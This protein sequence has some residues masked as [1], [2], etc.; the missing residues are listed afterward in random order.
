MFLGTG[1][2][3]GAVVQ[4][5]DTFYVY[6]NETFHNA[7]AYGSSVSPGSILPGATT[8]VASNLNLAGGNAN[9]GYAFLASAVQDYLT[10][11]GSALS[12]GFRNGPSGLEYFQTWATGSIT[13]TLTIPSAPVGAPFG[14]VGHLMLG[15][16]VTGSVSPGS[17]G[18][19]YM[20]IFAHTSPSLPNTSSNTV[21]IYANGHYNLGSPMSFY[22]D[23]PFT[24]TI[25]SNVFAAVAYDYS[26]I[27]SPAPSPL[28][29]TFTNTSSANFLHTALL[30]SAS[31]LDAFGNP[32]EGTTIN[33]SSG[34]PFPLPVPEPGTLSLLA[35]GGLALIRR[36][37][38]G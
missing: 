34:L 13:E 18:S 6:A 20:G 35:L 12:S 23:T 10:F 14:S 26:G 1:A 15:W 24:V 2:V 28:P 21:A 11:H 16:D 19:A 32:L 9:F 29:A 5:A 38:T 37:H 36:C 4:S 3:Y 31:A 22:Y 30:T 33:T 17:S 8:G 7:P 27:Y 25:D